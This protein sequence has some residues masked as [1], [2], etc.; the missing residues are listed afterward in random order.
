MDITSFSNES[1]IFGPDPEFF[2]GESSTRYFSANFKKINHN[3]QNVRIDQDQLLADFEIEWPEIWAT[4][5]GVSLKP[6]IGTLDFFLTSIQLVETYLF[7]VKNKEKSQINNMWISEFSCKAGRE[8]IEKK[9]FPCE[10]Q[11]LSEVSTN[12]QTTF[13][14]EIKI[15][16]AKIVL[17]I[18]SSPKETSFCNKKISAF[19]DMKSYYSL[20]YKYAFRNITNIYLNLQQSFISADFE[21]VHYNDIFYNGIGCNHMP[22]ITFCDLVLAAGQLSQILLF[23]LNNITREEASNLWLRNIRCLYK[24]PITDKTN[25]VVKIKKTREIPLKGAVYNCTDLIFDF[26]NGSLTAE[27]GSAYQLNSK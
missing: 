17:T 20:N 12:N 11:L 2:L 13:V 4:K 10:C 16:T 21:L 5:K 26:N 14:F 15:C 3:L 19:Y 6:H 7:I 9:L 23:R 24:S 18:L 22:C 27:C 8:C 1:T 25:V